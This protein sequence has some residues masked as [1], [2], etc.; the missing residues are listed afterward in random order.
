[1]KTQ[2]LIRSFAL[3][4]L[5]GR[6]LAADPL[7]TAFTYQGK[8]TEGSAP[9]QGNYDLWFKVYD[10]ASG[11]T[12]QGVTVTTNALP[13]NNGLFTITLDFGPGVLSGGARWLEIW[14]H[15]NAVAAPWV[16]L[17]PRQ[18]L[19]PAPY[20]LYAPNAGAAL[21]AATA[22][23][24]ATA[25][26]V[27]AGGVTGA[28]I[29]SGQVVKSLSGLHDEV[30]LAAGTN[31][32]ITPSGNSL[33]ISAAGGPAGWALS[34]NTLSSNQ[35]LGSL[36]N[37]PLE[38]M[39][40]GG[41][42]LRLEP[43]WMAP[44]LVGGDPHNS[45]SGAMGAVIGGGG[46]ASTPNT[47]TGHYGVVG[48]GA[49]NS[50]G[51]SAVVGGGGGSTASGQNAVI[52]GGQWNTASAH[53][54]TVGGGENNQATAEYATVGGGG[55][56]VASGSA[57]TV[58]GGNGNLAQG[59]NS[60]AAGTSA[61]AL[62]DGAFVW[63]DG[64]SPVSS[65]APN[66]FLVQASGG[67]SFRSSS[68]PM[69]TLDSTGNLSTRGSLGS[70]T[71][72]LALQVE[73]ATGLR[74]EFNLGLGLNVIEGQAN[75]IS[76]DSGNAA[77]GGGYFNSIGANASDAVIA[78]GQA[79]TIQA[80][81]HQAT[82]GGGIS[83]S[84]KTNSNGSVIAGGWNNV[85]EVDSPFSTIAGGHQNTIAADHATIAGGDQNTITVNATYAT[86]GGG[87]QNSPY[88]AYGTVPGGYGNV[89]S[90]FAF[91]AGRR[92]KAIYQGDFV[93]A[94]STDAD[95][96]GFRADEFAVRAA[97]GVRIQ[98]NRGIALN[99][100][101]APMMTRAVDD[102]FDYS[103]SDANKYGLGRWGMFLE[104]KNLVIGIPSGDAGDRYLQVCKY[105]KDGSRT[106][107][108]AVNQAGTCW[109]TTFTPLSAKASK[110]NFAPVEARTVLEKVAALPLATWNFK[111]DQQSR[112]LGP[113][114]EDF[115]AAFGLGGDDQHI[116]TVDA[117][118]VA[119]AAIQGLNQKL[120]QTIQAKD[121]EI[122]ALRQA[123]AQ[124]QEMVNRLAQPAK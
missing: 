118:G 95:F 34:G 67:V 120:D 71:G 106:Q 112:H 56:N 16:Y 109:A 102:P 37:Q 30:L 72:P 45:A 63:G 4:A 33:Q 59:G 28:S 78:G 53:A 58:P 42:A 40:N 80:N 50:A 18:P 60:F 54:T 23:M 61:Q 62:H 92:A 6:L 86:I 104:Y 55:N 7:G 111:S 103:G 98:S 39:V 97:G 3:L 89:A 122:Q 48:G 121:A 5:S 19:T 69:L 65:T 8:L 124:L 100:A 76:P 17:T 123:V 22:G 107:L 105:E 79:S 83:H 68:V 66:Q 21:S 49:G 52:V 46:N 73:G 11:G 96:S 114:A 24:A 88:G 2:D 43:T 32:T 31:V 93:W 119:L 81:A 9:A 51:M 27:V 26:N 91:A 47:V 36:N 117:D 77:I 14:V 35:F 29:G 41:R 101:W 70:M 15:T 115:R 12:Q 38:F 10:A 113:V 57:A 87:A 44:N 82:I 64:S 13:V 110:E 75:S 25:S 90:A 116:A 1:M 85:I 94:D 99:N 20:A 74:L 84:I 108:L